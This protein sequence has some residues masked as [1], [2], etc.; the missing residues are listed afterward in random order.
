[1]STPRILVID[2]EPVSS[3]SLNALL[4]GQGYELRFAANG[5][6]G[7]QMAESDPPDLILLDVMMPGMNGFEVCRRVR[8][9]AMLAEIPVVMITALD[10]PASRLSGIESGADDF[11]SKPFNRGEL[12]ARVRTITRLNRYRRLIVQTAQMQWLLDHASDGYLLLDGEE[13]IEYA[14]GAARRFLGIAD[15]ADV[16]LATFTGL[17]S[18]QRY[19]LEP[20]EAWA[21]WSRNESHGELF[22]LRPETSTAPA[23]WVRVDEL[24]DS[25]TDA[26]NR[27]IRLRDVTD[28][29]ANRF[30]QAKFSRLIAHKLNTPLN[31]ISTGLF[32]LEDSVAGDIEA[33]EVRELVKIAVAGSRQL[34]DA[35]Q[36]IMR[37]ASA[38]QGAPDDGEFA[39]DD[40]SKQMAA[41]V[42]YQPVARLDVAVDS[43][44][45][46][47]RL[48]IGESTLALMLFELVE[49]SRKFHPAGSPAINVHVSARTDGRAQFA[50]SDDGIHLSPRQLQDALMPFTQ[51]E[52]FATG[53]TPGMGLGLPLVRNLA[54]QFGGEVRILNRPDRPGIIVEF[55]LPTVS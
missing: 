34:S 23:F 28:A 44:L 39:L 8:A 55:D 20:Q 18:G 30:E 7:L 54:W 19:R 24:R 50:L 48:A 45:Q 5:A 26:T 35:V 9:N 16:P 32:L 22:L 51:A 49:N 14:N 10:D 21:S 43:A 15:D 40:L 11:I 13:R 37:Y 36:Q 41:I 53:E 42:D 1:M 3:E 38:S 52:K 46:S 47:K 6:D 27:L 29:M 12:R 31:Q 17:A 2:D 4:T 33:D 25:R